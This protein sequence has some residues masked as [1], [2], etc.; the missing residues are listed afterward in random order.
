[1]E[2]KMIPSLRHTNEVTGAYVTTGTRLKLYTYLDILQ[3][4]APYIDT[5]SVFYIQGR[6]ETQLVEWEDR[7]GDMTNELQPGE[8]IEEFVRDGPKNYAYKIVVPDSSK[9]KPVCKVRGITL[10]YSASQLVNFESIKEIILQGGCDIVVRTEKKIKRT[11]TGKGEGIS[12]I[13][14]APED[15]TYRVS[16][17]KRRR[18]SDNNSVSFGYI[19]DM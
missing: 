9:K 13:V 18:L 8:Y 7:L 4:K 15:R 14:A 10:N 3:E 5:D 2:E 1:M 11:R 17:L 16:F 6:E 19:K 12:A